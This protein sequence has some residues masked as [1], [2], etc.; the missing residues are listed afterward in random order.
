MGLCGATNLTYSIAQVPNT[1]FYVWTVPD[2]MTITSGQGTTSIT[3]DAIPNFTSGIIVPKANNSCGQSPTFGQSFLLVQGYPDIPGTPQ[4]PTEIACNGAFI[5]T[6][7]PV[8]GA[9]SYNWTAP[10]GAAVVYGQG[11]NTVLVKFF[12]FSGSGDI[13]VDAVNSCGVSLCCFNNCLTV[14]CSDIIDFAESGETLSDT[15]SDD[16]PKDGINIIEDLG[17]YPNPN[18]GQ[19]RLE[20]NV[21]E[22]G[23]LELMVFSTLGNLVHYERR[24]QKNAGLLN[25]DIA[26]PDLSDG[27]Y[28]LKIKIG[29]TIW[30]KKVIIMR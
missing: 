27:T 16:I 23:N 21:A 18:N 7:D 12:A 17:I 8:A 25:E 14:T 10:P 4:G 26:L 28:I 11:T 24:G 5:Y 30:N 2:G 19:F 1:D 22:E 20:G 29:Q 3:V 6:I 15:F 9:D 13:C